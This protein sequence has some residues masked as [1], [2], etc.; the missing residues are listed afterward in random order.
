[1]IDYI[2]YLFSISGIFCLLCIS[3]IPLTGYLKLLTVMQAGLA[4]I[5]AYITAILVTKYGVWFPFSIPIAVMGTV[6][7]AVLIF[8]TLINLK[9]EGQ[10]LGSLAVQIILVE[11]ILNWDPIT[12]G[13]LGITGVSYLPFK[14]KYDV[15]LNLVFISF[16]LL[17]SILALARLRKSRIGKAAQLVGENEALAKSLGIDVNKVRVKIIALSALIAGLAG[18]VYAHFYGYVDPSGF[19]LTESVLVLCVIVIAGGRNLTIALIFGVVIVILPEV[20]RGL[21]FSSDIVANIRQII[22]GMLLLV[23]VALPSLKRRQWKFL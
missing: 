1:M 3:Q 22:V 11:L 12:N 17:T 20:L 8:K 4:A 15:S 9:A 2:L 14:E 6:G 23:A 16:A 19:N 7:F 5:G 13:A 10:I 18:S 21:K